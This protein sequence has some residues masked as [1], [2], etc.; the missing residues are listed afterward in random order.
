MANQNSPLKVDYQVVGL[1]ALKRK[2]GEELYQEAW[3]DGLKD[4]TE[5]VYSHEIVRAPV[6][7]GRLVSR[8]SQRLDRRPIPR[9]GVVKTTAKSSKGYPYP[10]RLNF[11]SRSRHQGWFTRTA[12]TTK[13]AWEQIL[14]RVARRIESKWSR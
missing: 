5:L 14:G 6:R 10:R 8:M 1:R 2:L 9:Y 7:S 4:I 13:A 3:R 12:L 11:D